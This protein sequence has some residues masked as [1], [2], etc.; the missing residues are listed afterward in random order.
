M[1]DNED[2]LGLSVRGFAAATAAKRPTPGG[3]SVAGVVGALGVALGEMALNF[4][5]GK[6]KYAEH[7]EYYAHLSVRMENARRMFQDL[8]ADDIAAYGMYRETTQMPDGPEKDEAMQ[9]ATAA[10]ID[11]PRQA[12]K[13]ALAV[14]EDLRE[15]GPKSNPWLITDL[16]AS[17]VLVVA[18]IRLSDFNVRI[19]VPQVADKAAAEEIRQA[20]ADDRE[21]ANR[22]LEGLEKAAREHLP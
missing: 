19:N 21:K 1:A 15:L 7:E 12:T 11:V 14:L 3:G 8:V 13:L 22:I 16:L 4:T 2:M 6:K 17:G 9:L 20:S 18:A 10:A 5:K